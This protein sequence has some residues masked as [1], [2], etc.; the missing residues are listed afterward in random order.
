MGVARP[1]VALGVGVGRRRARAH[2]GGVTA[3]TIDEF[4]ERSDVLWR[5]IAPSYRVIGARDAVSLHWRF[6]EGP[7]RGDYVR[8]Y[9]SHRGR[10]I[11]HVVLRA[12]TW[13]GEPALTIVDYLGAPGDLAAL[14]AGSVGIAR[15]HGA[16]A[17]L[18]HTRNMHAY[19]PL[20]SSGFLRRKDRILFMTHTLED[21]P[22]RDVID[23]P[24]NWFLTAADSDVDHP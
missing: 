3:T 18:C 14:F 21:D 13:R 4:D 10:L 17:L 6:D 11:G 2:G 23:D 12:A 8:S 1:L 9:L 24:A 5:E 16:A 15:H 19:R 20:R 7:D 22:D